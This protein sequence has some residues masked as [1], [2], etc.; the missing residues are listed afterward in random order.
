M[1]KINGFFKKRFSHIIKLFLLVISMYYIW[2]SDNIRK[3]TSPKKYWVEKEKSLQKAVL[4]DKLKIQ[5]LRVDL[6]KEKQNCAFEIEKTKIEANIFEKDE[7]EAVKCL[8]I[9]HQ[10]KIDFINK[11]IE[12]LK[13]VYQ[14]DFEDLKRVISKVEETKN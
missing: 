6:E 13:I 3:K 7:F 14:K 5:S 2:H 10:K 1:R 8:N 4:V 12:E 9:N 11:S